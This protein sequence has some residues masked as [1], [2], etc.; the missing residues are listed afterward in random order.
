[1]LNE[2]ALKITGLESPIGKM[3]SVW[4]DEGK[5]IGIVR[6]FHAT[7]LHSE[8]GPVVFTLS[9]RHG[10]YQYVFVKIRP[11][12][13]QGTIAYLK[14]QV[15]RFAPNHLFE[16]SF[17]DEEFNRQY[18]NDL[19]RG[20][21]FSTFTFLAIFIS[22]LGLFGMAS[23]TAE[24]RRKEIGL[25]KILG[26]SIRNIIALISKDFLLLLLFANIIAWPIAYIIMDN[27]LKSYAYRTG[28][29]LWI[30]IVSGAAV[31]CIAL[32]TVCVKILKAAY[33]NPV[34]SLRYE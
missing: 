17:M 6:D 4:K 5:I 25:R 1:M 19:R 24:Q 20:E 23:F 21:I 29:A 34:D 26:A 7:S 22:C 3:F 18:G 2:E 27:M 9:Q 16:Y 31:V 13:I 15:N 28:I 30:F 14:K 10:S 33:S 11:G 8:I 32:V 12:D